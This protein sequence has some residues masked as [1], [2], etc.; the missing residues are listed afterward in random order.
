MNLVALLVLSAT[1]TVQPRVWNESIRD[2]Y[3]DGKLDRSAQTLTTSAPR[4][5][6]VVCGD[7]VLLFD[8]ATKA[9]TR[10]PKSVF[11]FAADR[12]SATTAPELKTESAGELVSPDDA[13]FLA[14]L[15]GKSIVIAPHK[16][17]AGTMT[18]DELWE[19][20]PVWR[21][22]KDHYEPD[23]AVVERLRGITEPTRLEVVMATWC[24]DSKQ[25]VPRLLKAVERAN[26]PNLTV[27][28]FGI[29]P[30]FLSPMA[31]VQSESITNVPTVIVRRGDTEIGR[32]V[33]TPAGTSVEC[34]IADIA[35]GTAKPH[36][37]RY[38][39]GALITSGIYELRNARRHPV[40]T[41]RFELYERPGGGVITHSVIAKK[42]GT[43]VETW[44]ALDGE[45]KP[46]FVEVTHRGATTTRT[47]YRR[48]GDTWAAH[49]RG[50][51]GGIIDQTVALPDCVISPATV[52]Y[53]WACDAETVYVAAEKGIGSM[54]TTPFEIA[55]KGDIPKVVRFKDG[56][57]RRLIT[58]P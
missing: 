44:A 46:R 13:V 43:S 15:A 28:V 11:A 25:H 55:M 20:A 21:A 8:P 29:G 39:R 18:L 47:R 36:P 42:D 53:G 54:Q 17:K 56:S 37:G 19:T 32:F 48:N 9:V 41:E 22:I 16:S 4:M 58:Q 34:D 27:E 5:I 57:E 1:L 10:A 38:E 24:G 14:S 40:G 30:D 50:A 7:E 31:F 35:H 26:N 3:V 45:K 2:V 12:N 23:A 49:S 6:A 52:T 51:D 33:E